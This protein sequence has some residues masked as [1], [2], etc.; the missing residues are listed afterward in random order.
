MCFLSSRRR[1]TSCSLVTGVQ[2]CALPVCCKLLIQ[3]EPLC[4]KTPS[5]IEKATRAGTD[6]VFIGL[7]NNNPDNLA[8]VKK[9][10]N[11]IW[12]YRAMLQEWKRRG[13]LITAGYLLGVHGDTPK[14]IANGITILQRV[15]IGRAPDRETG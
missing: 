3:D 6:Q 13:V 2:M 12:E 15:P 4:H 10:Q 14:K 9:R 11:K 8:A 1:H 5:F 7:E